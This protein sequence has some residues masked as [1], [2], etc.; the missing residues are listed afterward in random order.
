MATPI[1]SV[2]SPFQ[3][4]Y[5]D[6]VKRIEQG[7][8]TPRSTSAT[9]VGNMPNEPEQSG[10]KRLQQMAAAEEMAKVARDSMD[11]GA[12]TA[13]P[14]KT[15][16]GEPGARLTGGPYKGMTQEQAYEK[17]YAGRRQQSGTAERAAA[18]LGLSRIDE[19]GNAIEPKYGYTRFGQPIDIKTSAGGLAINP[20]RYHSQTK[21]GFQPTGMDGKPGFTLRSEGSRQE[22]EAAYRFDEQQRGAMQ[23]A[24][25]AQA[26]AE[27][28]QQQ[29]A[30]KER[31]NMKIAETGTSTTPDGMTRFYDQGDRQRAQTSVDLANQA[32]IVAGEEGRMDEARQLAAKSTDL[33]RAGA[34]SS[35]GR[36]TYMENEYGRGMSGVPLIQVNRD[37]VM[38]LDQA[39][40]VLDGKMTPEQQAAGR[41]IPAAMGGA[42]GYEKMMR[43]D[44]AAA[45]DQGMQDTLMD[46]YGGG[47]IQQQN[48]D[49]DSGPPTKD[50]TPAYQT[51]RKRRDEEPDSMGGQV[52]FK[53]TQR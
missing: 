26:V 21:D 2:R 12:A 25:G 24:Q 16:M 14:T 33:S 32:R 19:D 46:Q 35:P 30:E 11:F 40:D 10:K 3:F 47:R 36:A 17:F 39:S 51:F 53:N 5:S 6:N 38:P 20:Y 4:N 1:S 13:Y 31:Q 29:Q 48:R 23:A 49:L 37:N 22:R 44:A 52:S 50:A 45:I 28:K 42:A 34:P 18:N 43:D 8:K 9:Q 41:S 15:P 27:R 7:G